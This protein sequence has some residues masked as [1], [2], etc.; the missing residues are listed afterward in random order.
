MERKEYS[1]SVVCHLGQNTRVEHQYKVYLN[2]EEYKEMQLGLSYWAD[3][4]IK[5]DY[6]NGLLSFY[7]EHNEKISIVLTKI[8]EISTNIEL[9]TKQSDN[10]NEYNY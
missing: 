10:Q 9:N 2:D 5:N 4:M 8:V 7:N 6:T 3:D 1:L